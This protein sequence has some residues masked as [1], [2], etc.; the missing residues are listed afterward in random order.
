MKEVGD[1]EFIDDVSKIW[2]VAKKYIDYWNP[3]SDFLKAH[4]APDANL[5]V[6]ESHTVVNAALASSETKLK[7]NQ[8]L[9]EIVDA[10]AME[11]VL[12]DVERAN[13][14]Y[15]FCFKNKEIKGCLWEGGV[16]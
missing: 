8:M 2:K 13:G 15:S 3:F 7:N 6:N 4:M 12:L 10:L 11:E 5:R 9:N 16:F 14:K 1:E